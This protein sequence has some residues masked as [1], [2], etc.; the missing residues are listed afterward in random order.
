M[1]CQERRLV[2]SGV[3]TLGWHQRGHASRLRDDRA[4]T[5]YYKYIPE[6]RINVNLNNVNLV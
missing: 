2:S 5:Y 3:T 1:C 4:Y 6:G